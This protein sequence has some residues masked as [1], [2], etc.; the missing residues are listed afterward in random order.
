MNHR[1]RRPIAWLRLVVLFACLATIAG[2]AALA[3]SAEARTVQFQF[4]TP[5]P[6]A[7]DTPP[8]PP[9]PPPTDTPGPPPPPPTNT[10]PGP[11]PPPPTNTPP[12]PPP[13]PATQPAGGAPRTKSGGVG[14]Q[15]IPPGPT[16]SKF[17]ANRCADVVRPDAL[18]L[19]ENPGFDSAFVAAVPVGQRVRVLA[20][21][22]GFSNLW[23]WRFRAPGGQVGWGVGDYA[24][25]STGACISSAGTTVSGAV[26]KT[27]L[28]VQGLFVAGILAVVMLAAMVYRRLAGKAAAG[29]NR[30]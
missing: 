24:E 28:E 17:A 21:P 2:L 25:A 29:K 26:P 27:G 4:D 5:P 6:P 3:S 22:V 11:P 23:W 18:N 19:Y 30:S 8:G 15:A 9:P 7:T 13:P 1:Q 16:P 12:G 10:P 14:P 20:G